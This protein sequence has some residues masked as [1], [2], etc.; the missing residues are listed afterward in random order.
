MDKTMEMFVLPQLCKAKLVKIFLQKL[1]WLP[2]QSCRNSP[3]VCLICK[4]AV[5]KKARK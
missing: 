1:K 5:G 4:L 3:A 2:H